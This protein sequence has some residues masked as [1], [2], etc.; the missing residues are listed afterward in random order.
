MGAY[1]YCHCQGDEPV[2]MKSPTLAEALAGEHL[3]PACGENHWT[4]E[5][6]RYAIEEMVERLE[7]L[8]LKASHLPAELPAADPAERW[9]GWPDAPVSVDVDLAR[10]PVRVLEIIS[11]PAH[12]SREG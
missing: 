11:E 6:R 8:E 5:N 7:A 2:S 1:R 12:K 10:G 4:P 9:D 3:C